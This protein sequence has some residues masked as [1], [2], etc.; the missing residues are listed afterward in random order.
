MNDMEEK[1]NVLLVEDDRAQARLIEEMFRDISSPQVDIHVAERLAVALQRLEQ[2]T[3]AA[4]LLDLSLPDSQGLATVASVSAKAPKIPIVVLTGANDD[5]LAVA[6][7]RAG[8]QDYLVK[9][10][11]N[12]DVLK[13]VLR[14]AIERKRSEAELQESQEKFRQLAGSIPEMFWIADAKRRALLYVSPAF[15]RICGRPLGSLR[16]VWR[17]WVNALHPDDRERMLEV[18]RNIR[19]DSMDQ[20][21]RIVQPDGAV[22]WV[23]QRGSLVHEPDGEVS[24]IV[25]IIE[26]VT[27]R[28]LWQQ[29]LLHLAHHDRLTGLPNRELFYDRLDHAVAQA[30]RQ[31]WMVGVMFID[32]DGFKTINDTLGHGV[33]DQLLQQVATRLENCIRTDDTVGRLGGDEFAVILSDV[34]RLQDAGLVAQKIIS[35]LEKSF[36]IDGHAVHVTA[37]VGIATSSADGGN[38]DNLIKNADAAMYLA[39]QAGKNNYKFYNPSDH[40]DADGHRAETVAGNPR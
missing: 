33:G 23:H 11:V 15:Q 19:L 34:P 25:G 8:A 36:E 20:R 1:L 18:Y 14:Y 3:L 17:D 38:G 9:D 30:R 5:Q 29:S 7:V 21:Y 28:E 37:S 13:R 22:R 4:V 39:K 10:K 16:H 2:Q 32:L 26:D 6:A 40:R 35:A 12:P 31:H 27:E 24:R